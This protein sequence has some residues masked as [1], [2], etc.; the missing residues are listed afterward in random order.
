[1]KIG[2]II[3]AVD[4]TPIRTIDD[5]KIDLLAR[6]KGEKVRVRVLRKGLLG[7]REMNFDVVL[8]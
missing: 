8:Q 3:L 7:S 2:D 6:K 5:V 4:H 1:M